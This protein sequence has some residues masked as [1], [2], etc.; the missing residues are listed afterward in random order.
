MLAELGALVFN[1]LGGVGTKV[2]KLNDQWQTVLR[3]RLR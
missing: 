1:P 3:T 2:A